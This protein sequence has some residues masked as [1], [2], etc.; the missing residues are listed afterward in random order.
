MGVDDA[1]ARLRVDVVGLE[2]VKLP[3]A[4]GAVATWTVVIAVLVP[5]ALVAVNVYVI[6]EVG[7]TAVEPMSVLVEKE[8][9]VMA[10][11]EA[12]ATDQLK[13]DV[14]AEATIL[15]EAVKEDMPGVELPCDML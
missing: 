7:F 8:P 10:T 11:E 1:Q 12:F 9:G 2:A 3:G 5:F 14:P 15:E 6:V 13:V 4:V